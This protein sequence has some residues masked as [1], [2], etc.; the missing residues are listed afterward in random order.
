MKLANNRLPIL[1]AR[2]R[3]RKK[4][5]VLAPAEAP[6]ER[7]GKPVRPMLATLADEPFDRPDWL[8]EIKWDGYRAIA[9]VA[10]NEVRLYSRRLLPLGDRFPTIVA[11]LSKF[12]RQVIFDGEIVVLDSTGR[13]H[14]QYLQNYRDAPRGALAYYV[15]DVLHLD[16]RNLRGLPLVRRKE[17]LASVI[18]RSPI[19]HL[20]DHVMERGVSFFKAATMQGLEGIIAKDGSSAY[21][22]G[23]RSTDWL[24]IKTHRRQEAVI[25]G[26]TEPRR[27]RKHLGALLLGVYEGD[28]FVY[29]GH[30]GGGFDAA[31]LA[32]M[33]QRLKPLEQQRC[34]FVRP[35]RPNAPVHWVKPKLVC[36][37][38]FQEWTADGRMRQ[39]IFLGLRDDKPARSVRR[40]FAHP[41]AEVVD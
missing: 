37:V 31:G 26:F 21:R 28:Q 33:R 13:S 4:K 25:G 11:S 27:S 24:K 1:P 17:I 8:F 7:L 23:L 22:E 5:V 16:G 38:K 3:A 9:E 18:G 15:F 40:E 6:R 14:F 30:A 39:P 20:S 32:V 29:I 2:R 34:P 19:V 12:K 41:V 36:E 10:R 35:P